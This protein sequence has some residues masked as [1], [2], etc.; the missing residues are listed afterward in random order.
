MN[1]LLEGG[2]HDGVGA[3]LAGVDREG[4]EELVALQLQHNQFG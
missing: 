1:T 3:S 2:L 4:V